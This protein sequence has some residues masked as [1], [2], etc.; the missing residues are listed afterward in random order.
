MTPP[1]PTHVLY[2][3]RAEYDAVMARA[4]ELIGARF[5]AFHEGVDVDVLVAVIRERLNIAM[6]RVIFGVILCTVPPQ[7]RLQP[8]E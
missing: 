7:Q 5:G 3:T 4:E 6:P 2:L 1:A 8:I